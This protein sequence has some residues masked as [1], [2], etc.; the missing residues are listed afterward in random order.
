MRARAEW[1]AALAMTAALSGVGLATGREIA[2]FIGQTKRAAWVGVLTA[3][4][5]YGLVVRFGARRQP[6]VEKGGA[7]AG[8]C[9]ALRLILAGLVAALTLRRLGR[10]GELTLPLRHGFAFGMAFGLLAALLMERLSTDAHGR[11]GLGVA[12]AAGLFFAVSALDV[13]PA[14]V[15][16]IGAVDFAFEGDARMAVLLALP[17]AAMAAVPAVWRLWEMGPGAVIHPARLAAKC[18]AILA[19]LLAA[20]TCALLRGGDAV[21]AQPMPWVVLSARWGLAGFWL[22]ALLQ[23]LCAVVTLS[24]AL[25]VIR[26]AICR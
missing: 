7:L 22:C 20:A 3:S 1:D 25:G 11:I 4:V 5:L 18:A 14:R 23:A 6:G 13:R 17:Y 15:R 10:V 24:A 16:L 2:L 26:R 12:L 19:A 9:G 21:L 8:L